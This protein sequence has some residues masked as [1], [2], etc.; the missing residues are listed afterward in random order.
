VV[1]ITNIGNQAARFQV[2]IRYPGGPYSVKQRELA[3]GETATFDLRRMQDEQQPDRVGKM[4]PRDLERGQFHWSLANTRGEPRIIGRAEVVS[5]SERVSSSYSC[6]TCCPDSGNGG[7][8]DPNAYTLYVNGSA[9]TNGRG[10]YYDCYGNWYTGSL[11]FNSMWTD[12]T[13]VAT[14]NS[15]TEQLQGI[16]AG[17]TA[18]GGEY[19][20]T[21]WDTDGM[22]CYSNHYTGGDNAPVDV[23]PYA[24]RAISVNQ[25]DLGCP[26]GY[27]G[28]GAKVV[29]QVVGEEGTPI[30]KAGM[31]PEEIVSSAAGGFSDY[32]PFAT[33]SQTDASGRFNDIPIGTC[34]QNAT[35]NVCID[36]RQEFRIKVPTN[37]GEQ[38]YFLGTQANRRDCRDGI[39]VTVSTGVDSQTFTLGTVN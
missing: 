32:R 16:G 21:V 9:L 34:F 39:R 8:F 31:T 22:D 3:I 1:V 23:M 25:A 2:E 36:V 14:I 24:F 4:L 38:T 37:A 33:P 7:V 20:F 19:D 15:S 6:P 11:F 17:Q 18:V 5:S 35:S 13:S 30:N 12:N 10:D 28:Y 27:I 29:Y 26:S